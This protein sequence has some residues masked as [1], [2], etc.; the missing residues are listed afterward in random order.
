V[1]FND[2]ITLAAQTIDSGAAT[3]QLSRLRVAKT[4]R[5]AAKLEVTPA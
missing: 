1:G 2:G 4:A 3:S 5:D